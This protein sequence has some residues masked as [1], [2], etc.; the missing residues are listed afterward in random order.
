MTSACA[1]LA[2]H[3]TDVETNLTR[4]AVQRD[5]DPLGI[6]RSAA[7]TFLAAISRFQDPQFRLRFR[8]FKI[9]FRLE[10]Q[11]CTPHP[12]SPYGPY[13]HRFECHVAIR[14]S[15]LHRPIG[16]PAP[17][18]EGGSRVAHRHNCTVKR[19]QRGQRRTE[20][21]SGRTLCV[22][23]H[24]HPSPIHH[25]SGAR[26]APPPSWRFVSPTVERQ[27][28]RAAEPRR[29]KGGHAMSRTSRRPTNSTPQGSN[30][31]PNALYQRSTEPPI[32]VYVPEYHELRDYNKIDPRHRNRP[33]P[34]PSRWMMIF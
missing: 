7:E 33:L 24:P 23:G 13:G 14:V 25:V 9:P 10:A 19:I 12:S 18:S 34:Y 21:L 2:F 6:A 26:R 8:D 28:D 27:G 3:K 15:P 30:V 20:E 16:I 11:E 5:L 32:Y 4:R 31:A 1:T 29:R 22:L 17:A